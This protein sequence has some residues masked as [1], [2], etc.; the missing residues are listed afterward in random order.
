M[1]EKKVQ[2]TKEGLKAVQEELYE[3]EHSERDKYLE[4]LRAARALGDLSEN[5]DYDAAR[6]HQAE[7]EARI[8]ELQN[9][10]NNHEIVKANKKLKVV[11]MTSTVVIKELD[12]GDQYTYS[13][14][15]YTEA[16]PVAHKLGND[17]PLGLALMG[18][19]EGD[20]VT[21]N[22]EKPYQVEIISV[23]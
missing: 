17:S 2:I 4:E 8:T 5:A 1:A 18:Q 16:D 15:G 3:L 19:K 22:V 6:N 12:T 20:V 21:V 7:V 10:I 11:Q 13:I 14:V 23:N 9:I